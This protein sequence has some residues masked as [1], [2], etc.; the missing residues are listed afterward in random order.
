MNIV[1][2]LMEREDISREE[3]NEM[4]WDARGEVLDALENGEDAEEIFTDITG[5]EPEYMSCIL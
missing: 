3:A 4:L 5:L 1:K 2:L